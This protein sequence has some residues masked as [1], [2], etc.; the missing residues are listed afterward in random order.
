MESN[1]GVWKPIM[2]LEDFKEKLLDAYD[3]N[4]E[5]LLEVL[6]VDMRTLLDRLD[7]EIHSHRDCFPWVDEGEIE[8]SEGEL[9]FED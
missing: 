8:D 5:D 7:D 2:E 9:S 4:V 3:G 1:A 6:E